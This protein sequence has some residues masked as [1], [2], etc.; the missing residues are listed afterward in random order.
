MGEWNE[1]RLFLMYRSYLFSAAP[2]RVMVGR[3][4]DANSYPGFDQN[5]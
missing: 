1:K 4:W 2:S 3:G 5:R